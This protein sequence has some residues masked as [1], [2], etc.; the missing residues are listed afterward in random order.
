M[1]IAIVDDIAEHLKYMLLL[2]SE[3]WRKQESS[4]VFSAFSCVEDL[5]A[6]ISQFDV[7]F[8]DIKMP[9]KDGITAAKELRTM[10]PDII[11]VF[12][13]DYD[14]YVWDSFQAEPLYFLRK[15]FLKQELPLVIKKCRN[16]F[17][18]R[19]RKIIIDTA[20][21]TYQCNMMDIYYVEAQRK[22]CNLYFDSREI[23]RLKISF[24]RLEEMLETPPFLKVHRSYLVNSTY[25]RSLQKKQLILENGAVLP[26]SKYRYETV[27][28][29]YLMLQF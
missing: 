16:I 20:Q 27:H 6:V 25:I 26:V 24:S 11:I 23:K 19:N 4:A 7:V 12:V 29:Q 21:E 8:M 1:R 9:E 18:S 22:E 13:S 5:R 2:I 3:N 10:V 28:E 15:S 14:S 17:A